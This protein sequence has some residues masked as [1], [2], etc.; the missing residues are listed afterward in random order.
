MSACVNLI[1]ISGGGLGVIFTAGP[2]ALRARSA[3]VA[4]ENPPIFSVCRRLHAT[5]R[6]CW[7]DSA[8][9]THFQRFGALSGLHAQSVKRK[10]IFLNRAINVGRYEGIE[11]EPPGGTTT[12]LGYKIGIEACTLEHVGLFCT[13]LAEFV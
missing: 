12:Y 3:R 5:P 2:S 4:R 10:L 13:G 1:S 6:A 8:R 7:A 9:F 11:V